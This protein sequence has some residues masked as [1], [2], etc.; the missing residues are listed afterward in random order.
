M[1]LPFIKQLE[2]STRI[3]SYQVRHKIN[4]SSVGAK[5][6]VWRRKH[7]AKWVQTVAAASRISFQEAKLRVT[8]R[9]L[10]I[11][12]HSFCSIPKVARRLGFPLLAGLALT[13]QPGWQAMAAR[14]VLLWIRNRAGNTYI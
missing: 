4:G 11:M 12:F 5:Q 7:Q 8:N 14:L 3:F 6:S 10:Y 1:V 13:I 9:R 2:E